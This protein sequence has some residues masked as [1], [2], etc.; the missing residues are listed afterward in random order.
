MGDGRKYFWLSKLIMSDYRISPA[1][2]EEVQA[3]AIFLAYIIPH[4]LSYETMHWAVLRAIR[5]YCVFNPRL[6]PIQDSDW[7][8]VQP[9]IPESKIVQLSD[10][11]IPA[12]AKQTPKYQHFSIKN[13]TQ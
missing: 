3:E 6:I 2:L 11:R 13:P 7:S 5:K 9:E 12:R 8:V 4:P 1:E 10:Y